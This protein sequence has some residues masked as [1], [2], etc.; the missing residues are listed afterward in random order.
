MTASIRQLEADL[1]EALEIPRRKTVVGYETATCEDLAYGMLYPPVTSDSAAFEQ[2]IEALGKRA[3]GFDIEPVPETSDR[4]FEVRYAA[5][6]SHKMDCSRSGKL[7]PL[8]ATRA[9]E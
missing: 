8:P 6:Y 5:R 7:G 3:L 9:A 1:C 2:V 4:G